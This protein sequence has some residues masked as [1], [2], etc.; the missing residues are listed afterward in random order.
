MVQAEKITKNGDL[1]EDSTDF[2]TWEWNLVGQ[3]GEMLVSSPANVM[4]M[5]VRCL[6][7]V[8][9]L[10]PLSF[11]FLLIIWPTNRTHIR[12]FLCLS[13]FVHVGPDTQHL[14]LAGHLPCRVPGKLYNVSAALLFNIRLP[15][16]I[17][18]LSHLATSGSAAAQHSICVSWPVVIFRPVLVC[19]HSA[20]VQV[21]QV[22][23][24]A[25]VP[26]PVR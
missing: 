1:L 21:V 17:H 26:E 23:G 13:V 18:P 6:H 22:A 3:R 4:H 5:A 10:F 19:L 16:P 7:P 25:C 14:P 8:R 2:L 12:R 20:P 11:H 9:R 24:E 15:H